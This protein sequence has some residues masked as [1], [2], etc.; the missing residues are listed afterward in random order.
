MGTFGS[1]VVVVGLAATTQLLFTP[2]AGV[3]V[4][5]HVYMNALRI[6]DDTKDTITFNNGT[7]ETGFAEYTGTDRDIKRSFEITHKNDPVFE[8]YF[9]GSDTSIVS[10]SANTIRIPNHFYVTGEEL[11]YYHAGIGSTQ[12][13]GIAQTIFTSTGITTTLLPTDGIFAIKINDNEIQLASSASNALLPIPQPIDITSV[14]IG[15]SHRFVS[16]NQNPKVWLLLIT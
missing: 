3:D 8:R 14:G 1:N 13:I 7:I 11:K 6:E 9:D 5:V 2:V 15:T 16:T 4:T 12:A 10:V